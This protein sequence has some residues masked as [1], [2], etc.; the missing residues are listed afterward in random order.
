VRNF[1][2]SPDAPAAA[3]AEL[4]FTR[5][6]ETVIVTDSER[7][8]RAFDYLLGLSLF[9]WVNL[10]SLAGAFFVMHGYPGTWADLDQ[11]N[12]EWPRSGASGEH[13]LMGLLTALRPREKASAEA[14]RSPG[15]GRSSRWR[16]GRS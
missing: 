11:L 4:L 9:D 8:E 14:P 1:G 15:S 7:G 16:A 10:G 2:F 3:V 12:Q 6:C 13:P 5:G